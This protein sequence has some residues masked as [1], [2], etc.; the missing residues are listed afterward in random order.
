VELD[1]KPA[2]RLVN[3]ELNAANGNWT[4]TDVRGQIK[5]KEGYNTKF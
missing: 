1:A 5:N 2:N 4:N 3:K